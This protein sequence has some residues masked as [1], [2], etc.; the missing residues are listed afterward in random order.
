[1]SGS[2]ASA[3]AAK[4]VAPWRIGVDGSSTFTDAVLRDAAGA[5][6]IFKSPPVPA[7]A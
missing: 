3:V 7:R 6:R 5:V 1:M 4:L 2:P